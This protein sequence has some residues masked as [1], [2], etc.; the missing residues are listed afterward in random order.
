MK[1]IGILSCGRS[2]FNIY[3]P[4]LKYLEDSNDF[5]LSIIAFGTHTSHFHG[6][7]L[8]LFHEQGFK[9]II[10]V[11]ALLSDD[12]QDSIAISMGLTQIRMTEI[13]RNEIF[14]I[15]ICLGDRYE[16]FAAISS[17]LPFNLKVIHL[18]GGEKTLGA[19]DNSFRHAITAMSDIHL[20]SCDAHMERVKEIIEPESYKNVYNVG[21][22]SLVNP[23]INN[24]MSK[25]EFFDKFKY[26]FKNPTILCTYHPET[27]NYESNIQ[28]VKQL[29][30]FFENTSYHILFTLPNNDSMGAKLRELIIEYSKTNKKLRPYDFLGSR[31]YYSAMSHAKFMIGNTSSGIIEAASFGCYVV[32]VG[33]R[34]QGRQCSDNIYHVDCEYQEIS[35][36]IS[37]IESKGK[38]L[39]DNIYQKKN[40]LEMIIDIIK[41]S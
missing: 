1:K 30:K 34:Q 24:L 26:D 7:S 40:S 39:G 13:W 3:L 29:I 31:G 18:H 23:D 20:T 8:K 14:D 38:Y 6:Y 10:S 22:L 27:K 2:D 33:N 21:S 9:K 4:L 17:S 12:K 15:L 37:K 25:K 35:K 11:D 19:I 41:N 28:N 36:A 32:N 5:D 16:M